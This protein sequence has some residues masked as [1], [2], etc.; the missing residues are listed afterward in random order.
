MTIDGKPRHVALHAPKNGHVYVLDAQ[1]GQFLSATPF[2]PVNWTTGIDPKTGR[3]TIN[4]E[5][6][7]EKTGKP[8]IG[9]PGAGGAHS[10]QPQ[11]F[12]PKTNLLYIPANVAG[13]PYFA[14]KDW[15]PSG[16]GFQTAIDG[17]ATAMPADPKVQAGALAGTTGALIAWDVANR[18]VAWRVDQV[19]PWNGAFSRR[20]ATWCSRAMPRASSSPIAPTRARSCGRS[21]RRAGS[22]PRR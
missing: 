15:K 11:S 19:S 7:Y 1:T 16:M 10:W 4:P 13:F 9:L 21:R 17:Y 5:A 14:A 12:S 18:K 2:V 22:W 3:P 6:R 20:R 8:F